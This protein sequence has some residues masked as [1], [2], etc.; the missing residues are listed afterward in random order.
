VGRRING[1]LPR[2]AVIRKI[3]KTAI[4]IAR[5]FARFAIE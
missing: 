1:E 2:L 3:A 4:F 5:F